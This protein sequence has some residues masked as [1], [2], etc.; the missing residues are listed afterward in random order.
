MTITNVRFESRLATV[1]LLE[2]VI[3]FGEEVEG[4][5]LEDFCLSFDW[6]GGRWR[7][8]VPEGYAAAPSVPPLLRGF[9]ATTGPIRWASYPH[10]WIYEHRSMS[11]EDADDLFRACALAAGISVITAGRIYAAVRLGGWVAWAC[12]EGPITFEGLTRID[13]T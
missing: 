5:L 9:A 12:Y 1:E 2:A 10:D 8:T 13:A 6:D 7:L 3:K 11:R 4:I